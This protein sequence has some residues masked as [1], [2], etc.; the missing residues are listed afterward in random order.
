MIERAGGDRRLS[1]VFVVLGALHGGRGRA[2][3][4][5]VLPGVGVAEQHLQGMQPYE[6]AAFADQRV[7]MDSEPGDRLFRGGRRRERQREGLSRPIG[8]L[9][10]GAFGSRA[11]TFER[12]HGWVQVVPF[13]VRFSLEDFPA[14]RDRIHVVSCPAHSAAA[15]AARG[16]GPARRARHLAGSRR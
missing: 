5:V 7:S 1:F 16:G 4:R 11:G 13:T 2:F 8:V 15:V 9:A 3:I 14:G 10:R 12:D 6:A